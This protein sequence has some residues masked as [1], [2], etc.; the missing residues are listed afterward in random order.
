MRTNPI[1]FHRTVL[2][3]IAVAALAGCENQQPFFYDWDL[4]APGAGLS[5]AEAARQATVERPAPDNRG[6]ISYPGYQVAVARR[7]ETVA[8]IAGRLG[9]PAIEMARQNAIP[10]DLALRGGEVLVL[11]GRVSE[12]SRATGAVITGTPVDVTGIATTALDR[13]EGTGAGSRQTPPFQVVEPVRHRVQRGETVYTIARLHDVT[14]K[15]IA[16]WNGLGPDLALREGQTLLIPP[17]A[18]DSRTASAAAPA[19]G[20]GTTTPPPPSA[21]QPLPQERVAPA[22]QPTATPASPNLGSTRTAASASRL[23]MPVEGRIIRAYDRAAYRGIAIGA[24]AGAPVRAAGDGTVSF[25]TRDQS[26]VQIVM[27]QHEGGLQTVYANVEN[28]SVQRGAQVR[29]GQQ[30]GTVRPAEPPFLHFEVHRGGDR[31]D[32]M[33]FLQ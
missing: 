15:S 7:G 22:A 9:V 3:G 32:P 14:A 1:R 33:P 26:G 31:L 10:H 6:V 11:P 8:Q 20:R 12:P 29:R 21:S 5:T 4:R 24:A 28:L 17:P 23:A 25:I 30:I 13:A 27:V 19:P 18:V 2:A 16:D